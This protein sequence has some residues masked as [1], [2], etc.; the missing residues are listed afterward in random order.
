MDPDE[1]KRKAR[2]WRGRARYVQGANRDDCLKLAVSYETL[3]RDLER[4]S[5]PASPPL[6]SH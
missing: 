3:A 6:E 1:I 5:K 2:V 4:R